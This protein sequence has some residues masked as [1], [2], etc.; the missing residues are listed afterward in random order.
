[1]PPGAELGVDP[2]ADGQRFTVSD[3][4]IVVVGKNEEISNDD[5]DR[6]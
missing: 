4:G 1:M 2:E 5:H 6:S 3:N